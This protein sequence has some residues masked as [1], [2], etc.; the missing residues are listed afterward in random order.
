MAQ[1]H[2]WRYT[3]RLFHTFA[4]SENIEKSM[5]KGMPKVGF[6]GLGLGAQGPIDSAFFHD[7]G[8]LGK[9]LFFGNRSGNQQ[10]REN[11]AKGRQKEPRTPARTYFCPARLPRR[12][13]ARDQRES[14]NEGK[15]EGLR[16]ARPKRAE[17]EEHERKRSR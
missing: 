4:I 12:P 10:N 3:L 2:V 8:K 11:C 5:Q 7:F 9:S 1:N 14:R 13:R 6:F 15:E 17:V 16:K